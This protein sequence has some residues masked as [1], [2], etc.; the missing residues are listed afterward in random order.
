[1]QI[2]SLQYL[3]FSLTPMQQSAYSAYDSK[4]IN[5]FDH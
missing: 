2:T 5:I 4:N 3:I 1:M